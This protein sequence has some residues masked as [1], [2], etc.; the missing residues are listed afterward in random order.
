MEKDNFV[1]EVVF[2]KFKDGEVIALFPITWKLTMVILFFICTLVSMDVDYNHV[3]NKTKLITNPEEY[4]EL[5]MSLKT[6][7]II[8]K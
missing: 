2:R 6:L 3:V 1:T 5:K 4:N 7:V 8:L